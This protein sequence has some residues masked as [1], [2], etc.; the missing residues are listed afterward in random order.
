MASE[1]IKDEKTK[2]LIEG[3]LGV[4]RSFIESS[5]NAIKDKYKTYENYFEKEYGLTT[6][7]LENLKEEYMYK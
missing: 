3:I 5:L 6:E 7:A 2:K 1:Y 4:N